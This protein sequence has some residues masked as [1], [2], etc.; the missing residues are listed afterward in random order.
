LAAKVDL[1]N[2]SYGNY[3]LDVHRRVRQETYGQD[4]GQTSWATTQESN[5]IP[6]LLGLGPDSM[7]LEIGCGSG[8]YAIH[9]AQ[10]TGCRIGGVDINPHG[11]RNANRLASEAGL[12]SVRFEECDVS[13]GLPFGD[14]SFDAGFANDVTCHIR[15]RAGVFAEVFRVLK[16][17]G[18]FLFSDAS[19]IGGIVSDQELAT[20]SS[21]GYYEFSPT[22]ENERLLKNAGF[23][24]SSVTDTSH[25]AAELSK[26]RCDARARY[27]DELIAAEG[28]ENFEGLQRFLTCVHL[29]S[30]EKR[31]LRLLYQARKNA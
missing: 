15:G 4:L 6:K 20:R 27:R 8:R 12:K 26:R 1:Y 22:G 19:V 9:V 24:V 7:V 30:S 16:P 13:K 23:E 31:L 29:L 14:G 18:R 2:N 3:E 28:A 5:E 21:I 17:G 11:V 10:Q 25:A